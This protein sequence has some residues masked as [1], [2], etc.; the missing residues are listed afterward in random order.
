[1]AKTRSPKKWSARVTRESHALAL[2]EG[3]FTWKDPAKIARSLRRSAQAS[4]NR[5]SDPYR[6]AMSMLNFYL[7]RAGKSLPKARKDIL[8]DAKTALKK[9]FKKD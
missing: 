4:R 3:V 6:S 8:N 1:M 9:Q 7:N 2:E 5:K